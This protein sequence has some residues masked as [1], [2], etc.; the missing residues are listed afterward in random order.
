MYQHSLQAEGSVA[1]KNKT[2]RPNILLIL[3]DGNPT[4]TTNDNQLAIVHDST[5]R[6]DFHD[7]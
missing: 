7:A 1:M 4:T 5:N 2:E 3:N 6:I